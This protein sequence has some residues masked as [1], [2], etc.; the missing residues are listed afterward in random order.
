MED[1]VTGM[2]TAYLFVLVAALVLL[3]F[4]S[5]YV[6]VRLFAGSTTTQR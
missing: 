2:E 5:I 4:V 3:G 6:L 1:S